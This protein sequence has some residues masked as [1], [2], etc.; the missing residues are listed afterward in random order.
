MHFDNTLEIFFII[1]LIITISSKLIST[2][3]QAGCGRIEFYINYTINDMNSD[4]TSKK[5]RKYVKIC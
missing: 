2:Q 4:M 1:T 3:L 5:M